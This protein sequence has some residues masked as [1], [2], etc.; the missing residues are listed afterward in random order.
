M[1]AD[2]ELVVADNVSRTYGRGAAAIVAV[3][4]AKCRILAG[5]QIAL[6]GPSG[7]G[8]ST[9]LH[10]LAGLDPPTS[11]ELRWPGLGGSPAHLPAGTIGLVFQGPS[12]LPDLDI[13]ENVAFPLILSGRSD[14]SARAAALAL[15]DELSL[16][17]LAAK[18]PGEISGGQAQRVGVARAVISNPRLILADEPTGQLDHANA[19]AVIALLTNKAR[20]L[21]AGLLVTTHDPLVADQLATLWH[22]VDGRP[23]TTSDQV[24]AR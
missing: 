5:D 8:K 4:G 10:L 7:S 15:L 21:D 22:M 16:G 20:Q 13:A 11:G 18:L 6:V 3:H 14:S 17:E 1:T 24:V 12:L 9:L 2:T 19:A 23:R